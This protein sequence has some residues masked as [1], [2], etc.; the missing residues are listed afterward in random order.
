MNEH[1]I[2]IDELQQKLKSCKEIEM[3]CNQKVKELETKMKDSK[4]YREKQL[5]EAE[6]EMK[7]M[8]LKSEKSR[9]EWKQ[10]EQDYDTL[11]LEIS[12]LKK[13]L[14]T[15]RE[16]LVDSDENIKNLKERYSEMTNNVDEL[17][18]D[19]KIDLMI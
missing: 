4:G 9:N 19:K 11:N 15:T 13:G 16:Q 5:K 6:K 3:R 7:A 1:F 14:E 17:K 8:K 18:V 2:F 12:E 10:R